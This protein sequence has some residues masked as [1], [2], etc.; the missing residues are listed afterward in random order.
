M[1]LSFLISITLDKEYQLVYLLLT[2]S[3][4]R[5]CCLQF[6][7][8][9]ATQKMFTD[10]Q[11]DKQ[12]DRQTNLLIETP[13]LGLIGIWKIWCWDATFKTLISHIWSQ[14]KIFLKTKNPNKTI[15]QVT[16]WKINLLIE[17]PPLLHKTYK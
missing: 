10:R 9:Q 12:K 17:A 6:C 2:L 7:H 11:T 5:I 14:I 15:D 1:H 8:F 4:F 13:S 16:D 3:V